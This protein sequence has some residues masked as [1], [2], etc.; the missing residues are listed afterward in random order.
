MS[1]DGIVVRALVHELK[2]IVGA[3]IA[4]IYQP[5]ENEVVLHIRGQGFGRKLLL[6][7]HPSMPRLHYT[8]QPW[9]NPQEPPM[10]CM[11]LRKH[12][13]GGIIEAVR[14]LGAERI[15]E[16][17]VRHRDELGDLSLKRL[18][19][20][21]MGRHSN[22]VLLDPATG[23]VHDSI[24]HVTPAISSYRVVL[25]GVRY[26]PPPAQDKHN[27][28]EATAADVAVAL[29]KAAGSP[30][31]GALVEAFTGLSPLLAKEIAFRAG[32]REA[33]IPAAFAA[34]MADA[35]AHRYAPS[36]VEEP[37]GRTLFHALPL[38]HAQ[39]EPRGCD[40][41]HACLETYYIDKAERDLVRQR[42]VDLT[43][44]LQNET[45]K[46]VKKLEKLRQ[47]LQDAE[48][49]DKYRRLGELL[50]AHLY[51][52]SKGDKQVEVTDYYEE[53]QPTVRVQLDPLLTPNENAQRYFRKYTKMKNSRDVVTE[54]IEETE[55]EIAYLDS[56]LQGLDTAT[57][58][59]IEEIRAELTEQ[60]Y[61]RARGGRK[62][63][64]GKKKNDRPALLCY[65]SSEGVPI[66]VGKNNT[67]ND[68]VTN[69]LGQPS[70]TWL[71]TKDM[72]GSH[73]LIR[74]VDYGE[75]TL[76]EAAMLAAYYSKGKESSLV[77]VDYTKIRL[78]R[79]PSGAKPG[80]VIY[81]G[82]KTLFITPDESLVRNLP[83]VVKKA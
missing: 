12:C 59:D 20:E 73:V 72:P 37:A 26:V 17:D 3:R 21:I 29:S 42:T 27:P 36:I 24:R 47:T 4:K 6:S 67:Q 7:A 16:I 68:Y 70:D 74:A 80:F 78:V 64:R 41:M 76:K 53:D 60:G 28:L 81:E 62:G 65:T 75:Q 51:A 57:P 61:I 69:R 30:P 63:D 23:I 71:H 8:E 11:L 50:T 77:P 44:L 58:A 10:F 25:P 14:Q 39:G 18:V 66:Y 13:E 49:A 1:L 22:L 83:S 35:A 54:Q 32:G 56:V 15:V 45:A 46:N 33:D 9:A 34:L 5:T 82:Q 19:L 52:M 48:G 55:R 79:K 31:A 43:R 38:T 2:E 40:S